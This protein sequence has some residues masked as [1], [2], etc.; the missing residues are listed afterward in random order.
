MWRHNQCRK[1]HKDPKKE[2]KYSRLV[3]FSKIME[4]INVKNIEKLEMRIEFVCNQNETR[5][6]RE[7]R[8]RIKFK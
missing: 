6:L 4:L 3:A 2:L 5:K 7:K 1:A 8:N